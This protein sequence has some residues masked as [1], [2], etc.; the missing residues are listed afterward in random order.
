MRGI[1]DWAKW[2]LDMRTPL[3]LLGGRKRVAPYEP[4]HGDPP[5]YYEVLIQHRTR[6]AR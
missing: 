6:R 4:P 1:L 2:L 5:T 3:D